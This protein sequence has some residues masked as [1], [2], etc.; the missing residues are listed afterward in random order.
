VLLNSFH[1]T[2]MYHW[3]HNRLC[4]THNA[5]PPLYKLATDHSYK[6]WLRRMLVGTWVMWSWNMHDRV[7]FVLLFYNGCCSNKLTVELLQKLQKNF[8]GQEGL[9][10]QLFTLHWPVAAFRFLTVFLMLRAFVSPLTIGVLSCNDVWGNSLP[11]NHAVPYLPDW[12]ML[13]I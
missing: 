1:G 13:W 10:L 11:W 8:S 5:L 4:D 7:S 12:R 3:I 6:K 2:Y 9:S